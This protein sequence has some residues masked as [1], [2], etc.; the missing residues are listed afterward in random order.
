MAV[1]YTYEAPEGDATVVEVTFTDGTIAH[2][3]SVNAV[4]VDGVYDADATENRVGEVARG[5]E[6]KIALG[7]IGIPPS[8]GPEPLEE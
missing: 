7:V 1:T 3:R 8:G 4:F 2:T 6:H 5:V